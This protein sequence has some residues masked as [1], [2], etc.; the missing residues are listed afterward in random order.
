MSAKSSFSISDINLERLELVL[1][2]KKPDLNTLGMS[3]SLSRTTRSNTILPLLS[4][5]FS[6]LSIKNPF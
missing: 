3:P 5:T 4:I 6:S 1:A 2:F